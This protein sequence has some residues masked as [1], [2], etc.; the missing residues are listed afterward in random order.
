M[1]MTLIEVRG[2]MEEFHNQHHR[3][4]N[5]ILLPASESVNGLD[6][7]KFEDIFKMRVVFAA[8]SYPRVCIL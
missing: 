6:P 3:F 5:T 7:L 1:R 4:P 2:I 8:V